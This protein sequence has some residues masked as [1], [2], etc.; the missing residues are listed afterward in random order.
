MQALGQHDLLAGGQPNSDA[1]LDRS[2]RLAFSKVC[3]Y[4]GFPINIPFR[5]VQR[6]TK[7]GGVRLRAGRILSKINSFRKILNKMFYK[8]RAKDCRPPPSIRLCLHWVIPFLFEHVL[9]LCNCQ[10][11]WGLL[12]VDKHNHHH[13]QRLAVRAGVHPDP[14]ALHKEVHWRL[15]ARPPSGSHRLDKGC[16]RIL[17]RSTQIVCDRERERDREMITYVIVLHWDFIHK[18][19]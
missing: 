1:G 14:P 16:L 13:L 10:V 5:G 8:E 7:G 6:N 19:L 3:A 2:L 12:H 15:R 4:T 18:L 9:N 11:H 17:V